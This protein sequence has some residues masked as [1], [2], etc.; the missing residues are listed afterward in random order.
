MKTKK[1]AAL[2][3]AGLMTF[4]TLTGCGNDNV[5][6][7]GSGEEWESLKHNDLVSIEFWGRDEGTEK[8]NYQNYINTFN[9]EHSNIIVSLNWEENGESYNSKLDGKGNNLPD[10]FMLSNAMFTSY[11]ASGKLAN[12]RSHVDDALLDDLYER[13]RSILL[14]SY[15]QTRGQNG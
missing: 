4:A 9:S 1:F 10:V 15:D 14:R 6:D 2:L 3:L 7:D 11:A 13:V 5:I 8:I 12:I